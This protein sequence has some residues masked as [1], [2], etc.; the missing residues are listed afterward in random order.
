VKAKGNKM[1]YNK[2]PP[3]FCGGFCWVT[4]VRT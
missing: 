3:H 2:K 1:K 4:R